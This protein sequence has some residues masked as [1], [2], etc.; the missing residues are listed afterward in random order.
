[1]IGQPHFDVIARPYR[2]LEY[3]VFG[4]LL[5]RCRFHFA[6]RAASRER[7]LVLGDGDGRFLA[8]L[9]HNNP[10]LQ[11]DAVD[12]SPR[13]LTL[14]EKRVKF[15][16]GSSANIR[17][18]CL[19]VTKELPEGNFDLIVTHFF[20][21]CLTQDEV[22]A[23]IKRVASKTDSGAL[24][25]ISEFQIPKTRARY[26]AKVLIGGL[27]ISFRVLCGLHV[28]Q[29]PDYR[30]SLLRSGFKPVD[31]KEFMMGILSTQLWQINK[32]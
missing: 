25:L 32:S 10:K 19:D 4:R 2:W 16:A 21:D 9:Y 6:S 12:I 5:E 26:F 29:I 20:F 30:S 3:L 8:R 11:S 22:E 14:L 28:N 1:M 13:M 15:V 18:H 24:W 27:Y 23:L 31:S 7:A 17:T